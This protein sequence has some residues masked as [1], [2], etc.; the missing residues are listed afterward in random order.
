MSCADIS[1]FFY[2]S[3][4]GYYANQIRSSFPKLGSALLTL[5][6]CVD[7]ASKICDSVQHCAVDNNRKSEHP[8]FQSYPISN[9]SLLPNFDCIIMNQR[10]QLSYPSHS[11]MKCN[12]ILQR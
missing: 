4:L 11:L 9:A 1:Y 2:F 8:K 12:I 6:V 7:V 5:M 10:T 3:A